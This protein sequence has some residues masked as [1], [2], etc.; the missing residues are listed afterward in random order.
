MADRVTMGQDSVVSIA[1][2]CGLD[3]LGIESWWGQDFFHLSRMALGPTQ[4]PIQWVPG[5]YPRG[6]AARVWHC[7]P[8]PI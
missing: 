8:T 7:P 1:A 6:K 5:F 4:P 2:L 3:G